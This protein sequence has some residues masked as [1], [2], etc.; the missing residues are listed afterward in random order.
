MLASAIT[1]QLP[2]FFSRL[3][4]DF[5]VF[6]LLCHC[7]NV[8]DINS[9]LEVT[10]YDEDRDHRF[11]FLGTVVI[12]LLRIQNGQ[13]KW[14]VLKDRKLRARA[15]GTNPQILL[16]LNVVWNEVCRFMTPPCCGWISLFLGLRYCIVGYDMQL[17]ASIQTLQPKENKYMEPEMKF[18]RQAF[19]RNVMRIKAVV[20]EVIE[21]GKYIE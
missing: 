9:V 13:K 2:L 12:P 11:E 7:S 18:S 20:M 3:T 15:K 4:A 17:R 8:K 16:E 19:V 21:M 5:I 14:Y 1:R 10:V 6:F